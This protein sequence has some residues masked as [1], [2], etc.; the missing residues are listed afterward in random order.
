[1]KPIYDPE[2]LEWL[3]R[4]VRNGAERDR[5]ARQEQ[6]RREDEQKRLEAL[7]EKWRATKPEDH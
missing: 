2:T 5:R 6:Q 4:M 3:V 1:M 7:R